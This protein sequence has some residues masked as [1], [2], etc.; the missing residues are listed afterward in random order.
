MTVNVNE[1]H[2]LRVPVGK[3]HTDRYVPLHP[4]LIE[5]HRDLLDWNGPN[6]TGRVISNKR[7]PFNRTVVSRIV[8]AGVPIA[9]IGHI[10]PTNSATRSP[11]SR[12]TTACGSKPC[13]PC[14]GTDRYE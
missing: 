3:L 9:G 10:R 6:T 5:L 8:K 7:R 13:P 1:T 4:S 14:W 2:W 11:L 12:S